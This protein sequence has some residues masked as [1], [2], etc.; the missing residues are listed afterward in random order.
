VRQSL[1]TQDKREVRRRLR[2]LEAQTA[3]GERQTTSIATWDTA[4]AELLAYYQAYGTRDVTEAGYKIK[5][6]TS[7]FTGW[8]LADLNAAAVL[9]YV[10]HRRAQGKAAATI[11]VEL[12]TLKRALR[13][14]HEYGRLERV[15]P[16]K[17]LRPAPP[18][19]G[20]FEAEQFDAVASA[21]PHDLELVVRVGYTYGWRIDSEVLTLTRRQV[22]LDAGTL[23]LDPGTTKNRDARVAYLTPQLKVAFTEQL[24]QVKALERELSQVIPW[25]FPV[26][27]GPYKGQ[28]RKDFVKSWMRACRHAG[29]VGMLCHDLRRTAV[30]NMLNLGVPERVAMKITGHRTTSVFHRY[31]IVSPSDLQE[32]ARRL[33]TQTKTSYN[34]GT[35]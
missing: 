28:R 5:V 18:R 21:L 24:T 29:C 17:L 3:R 30:R 25:V 10:A 13:L 1:K 11:N 27:Y 14:A 32:A 34:S 12:A 8:K 23:R 20:F 33:A 31:H 15:P 35:G 9:G 4:A 2:E 7:Y 19:A 6:V 26:P 16:I 22:D